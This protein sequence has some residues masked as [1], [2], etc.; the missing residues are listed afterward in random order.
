MILREIN[1]LKNY[2]E[3][4]WGIEDVTEL[5]KKF[6]NSKIF[7]HIMNTYEIYKVLEPEQVSEIISKHQNETVYFITF[8]I[9]LIATEDKQIIIYED[10]LRKLTHSVCKYKN[11]ANLVKSV[12]K[13]SINEINDYTDLKISLATIS[14][15]KETV[16]WILEKN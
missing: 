12:I 11:K 9:L 7:N 16:A 15:Q 4:H 10:V 13:S 2:E 6:P 14:Q 5:Y 8:Y 3:K 1:D